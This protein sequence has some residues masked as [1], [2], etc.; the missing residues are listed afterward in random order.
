MTDHGGAPRSALF[1]S[2]E[3]DGSIL[4]NKQQMMPPYFQVTFALC[5]PA[6]IAAKQ[7]AFDI[8]SRAGCETPRC[9]VYSPP[10]KRV[11]ASHTA[12]RRD[13]D[14]SRENR[15]GEKFHDLSAELVI[16]YEVTLCP[17]AALNL[18]IKVVT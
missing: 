1:R 11:G 17:G 10:R 6:S 8:F 18:A 12:A 4:C 7:C 15:S 13:F 9:C 3:A 5:S 2:A 14:D 16:L